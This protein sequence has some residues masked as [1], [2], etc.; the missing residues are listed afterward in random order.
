MASSTADG[1]EKAD[2]FTLF[3]FVDEVESRVETLRRQ[4]S[5]LVEEQA[6]LLSV[7]E[8]LKDQSLSSNISAGDCQEL[9]AN[10][11]RLKER[12]RSIEVRVHTVRDEGQIEA[13]EK[14]NRALEDLETEVVHGGTVASSKRAHSF[15]NACLPDSVGAI[16]TRFQSM[17]LGCALD[18][19]KE[20]RRRLQILVKDF[21]P[22]TH[23]NKPRNSNAH[24]SQ[25]CF[26][27]TQ[28]EPEI[29]S[30]S[31][32]QCRDLVEECGANSHIQESV[33]SE[34]ACENDCRVER[35]QANGDTVQ[36]RSDSPLFSGN[37]EEPC[38]E[39]ATTKNT[40]EYFS[41]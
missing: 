29:S 31:D 3:S 11:E 2:S 23:S 5:I 39:G 26:A 18:D 1:D 20:V 28:A 4:A 17:I 15:L 34:S 33:S 37:D 7:L 14:V 41:D 13:L 10:M 16:D 30:E 35:V 9:I 19:Q 22:Q 8:Q 6:S 12:C 36:Q 25:E 38:F 27:T 32:Q 40:N 24:N 21:C